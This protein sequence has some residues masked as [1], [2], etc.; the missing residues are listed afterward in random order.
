MK[1]KQIYVNLSVSDLAKSKEFFSRLGYSFDPEFTN[2]Q[3]ACLI[4]G[5]NIYAMLLDRNFF[6]TF[7][8][9]EV[10]DPKKSVEVLTCFSVDRRKDVDEVVANAVKAGGK[11]HR[12]PQDFGFMYSHGFEDLDGHI[13]EIVSYEKA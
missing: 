11:S 10:I 7:T 13:W 3:G 5:E 12:S 4:L 9:K 6:R 2:E 1:A 8:D